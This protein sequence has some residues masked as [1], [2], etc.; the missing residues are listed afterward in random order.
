MAKP[1][2]TP[3]PLVAELLTR[4]GLKVQAARGFA[5]GV[6]LS[7]IGLLLA[8]LFTDSLARAAQDKSVLGMVWEAVRWKFV[9]AVMLGG[10]AGAVC[11][12]GLSRAGDPRAARLAG[13]GWPVV[14]GVG[15][16]LFSVAHTLYQHGHVGWWAQLVVGGLIGA[17][18]GPLVMALLVALDSLDTP[19]EPEVAPGDGEG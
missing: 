19:T 15:W 8:W 12:Y 16:V 14:V 9:V 11:F 10:L 1:E 2:T 13:R 17:C 4:R 7:G 18:A 6:A 3:N 5:A